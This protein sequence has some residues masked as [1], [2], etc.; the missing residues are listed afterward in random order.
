MPNIKEYHSLN[1]SNFPDFIVDLFNVKEHTNTYTIWGKSGQKQNGIDIFSSQTNTVIQ[2]KYKSD[3]VSEKARQA[4]KKELAEEV[5]KVIV[6]GVKLKHFILVSTYRH[7][8]EL[9]YFALALRDEKEYPF[10]ISYIGWDE[11]K[12]WALQFPTILNRYFGNLLKP[13]IIELVSINI[14]TLA[15]SWD[16]VEGYENIF[17]D[18]I[19]EVSPHPV[20][21]FTFINHY[22]K[23][24]VL[25]SICLFVKG[26]W[27]G[28]SGIPQPSK[29]LPVH[30]YQ[31][32][33]QYGK[34][35]VLRADPP[36]QVGANQAFRFKLQLMNEY[37]GKIHEIE[38]RNILFFSFDFNTDITVIAPKVYL[39]TKDESNKVE[40]SLM[41]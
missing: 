29:V 15:C 16:P 2:C 10:E 25:K 3:D 13:E 36:I 32:K 26:L 27:S 1:P 40:I 33:F 11:V 35:N 20:F 24:I 12:K 18:K 6:S 31:M 39:N 28:F 7:D 5:E 34:E 23:T 38:G 14:D 21:D 4:L 41:E 19:S 8:A 37:A 9:Q 17:Y 22:S 30:T